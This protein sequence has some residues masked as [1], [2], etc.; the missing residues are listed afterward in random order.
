M[1]K[2]S[3][4]AK[5]DL[6]QLLLSAGPVPVLDKDALGQTLLDFAGKSGLH[7]EILEELR[8]YAGLVE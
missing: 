5:W 2:F 8:T 6:Y 3:D 1:P 7:R 4:L